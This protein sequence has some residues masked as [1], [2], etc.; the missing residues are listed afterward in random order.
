MGLT[1]CMSSAC[2]YKLSMLFKTELT[3]KPSNKL[4]SRMQSYL[5]IVK[6]YMVLVNNS[7]LI[8]DISLI[9]LTCIF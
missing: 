7:Y 3:L 8:Y 2:I 4:F 5:D 6:V 9:A 1:F